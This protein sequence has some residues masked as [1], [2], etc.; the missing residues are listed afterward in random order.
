ML[1]L[2]RLSGEDRTME[3][4]QEVLEAAPNYFQRVAGQPPRPSEAISTYTMLPPGK[5]VRLTPTSL[6]LEFS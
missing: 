2:R 3:Q 1:E 4:L 6:F 5:R